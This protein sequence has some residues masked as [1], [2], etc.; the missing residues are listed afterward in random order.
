[1]HS[2][3][4]GFGFFLLV[5]SGGFAQST[6]AQPTF[7]VASVKESLGNSKDWSMTGGP[8]GRDPGQINWVNAPLVEVLPLA[9]GVDVRRIIG[10]EWALTRQP[11]WVSM[12]RY[13]IMAKI[14]KGTT[15]ADFTL[16][17]Q[18]LLAD[19]LKLAF[20]HETRFYPGYALKLSKH[21]PKM[22]ES[23]EH[24]RSVREGNPLDLSK[25][26]PKIEKQKLDEK[27]FPILPSD[28]PLFPPGSPFVSSN[29]VDGMVR[30][31]AK[32]ESLSDIAKL[33]GRLAGTPVIDQT[34]LTGKYDFHL[35]FARKRPVGPGPDGAP[36]PPLADVGP[37]LMDAVEG[38]LG[39]NMETAKIP[40]D[41]IVIDHLEKVPTEN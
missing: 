15:K 31:S 14:P 29:L 20:H 33:L 2:C 27:G 4:Y 18:N 24:A 40:I 5:A 9:F 34:G 13:T 22:K 16:M 36:A 26:P 38:Q 37:N 3:L 11:D 17:L 19:R 6:G 10:P 12:K 28:N 25:L 35:E 32:N 1:V 23:T 39:L 8:D 41:M 30:T 21:G 7:E